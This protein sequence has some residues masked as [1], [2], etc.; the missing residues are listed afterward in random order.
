M[1]LQKKQERQIRKTVDEQMG[2]VVK[3]VLVQTRDK[4]IMIVFRRAFYGLW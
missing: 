3:Y 4:L 1:H 2:H